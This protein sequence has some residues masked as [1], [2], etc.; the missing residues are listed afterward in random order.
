LNREALKCYRTD[1]KQYEER[2]SEW[3][4]KYA[5]KRLNSN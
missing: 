1:K 4:R 3:T 5:S 2:A